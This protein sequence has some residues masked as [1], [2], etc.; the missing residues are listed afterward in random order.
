M[1]FALKII[2]PVLIILGAVLYWSSKNSV[3]PIEGTPLP[4]PSVIPSFSPQITPPLPSSTPSAQSGTLMGTMT[5]G[6]VCPVEQVNNPCKPTAEMYA[7][8]KVFIYKT[9]KK[10]LVATLTPDAIG[11]FSAT[12]SV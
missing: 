10:T 12:L 11:K 7:A 5:I 2:I 1:K 8:R 6:P 9:D 3:L 4:S